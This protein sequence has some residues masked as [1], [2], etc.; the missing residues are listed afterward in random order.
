VIVELIL[1]AAGG[2]FGDR[3]YTHPV[4]L[5]VGSI[6]GEASK[7]MSAIASHCSW[8]W[9]PTALSSK[10]SRCS[11]AWLRRLAALTGCRRPGW[12]SPC[13]NRRGVPTPIGE[14]SCRGAKLLTYQAMEGTILDAYSEIAHHQP[15]GIRSLRALSDYVESESALVVL[16]WSH[17]LTESRC[18]PFRKML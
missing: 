12:G 1:A 13:A 16:Y 14:P 8:P 15:L 7:A 4:T 18:P 11:R 3:Y 17:F 9:G 6:D 5:T 2:L 10:G